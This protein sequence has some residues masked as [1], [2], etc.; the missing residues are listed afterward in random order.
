M[1]NEAGSDDALIDVSDLYD[2]FHALAN[3]VLTGF[4]LN[5]EPGDEVEFEPSFDVLI[6]QLELDIFL[7]ACARRLYRA[8]GLR[9]EP[10]DVT[11]MLRLYDHGMEPLFGAAGMYHS[12]AFLRYAPQDRSVPNEVLSG[13]LMPRSRSDVG[14]FLDTRLL[15]GPRGTRPRLRLLKV[16]DDDEE[17]KDGS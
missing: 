4:E 8:R 14:V 9:V 1:S 17:T 12:H 10:D 2:A 16:L 13:D 7:P 15:N 6:D 3:Q 5:E 11:R